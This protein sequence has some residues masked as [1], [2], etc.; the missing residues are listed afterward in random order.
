MK[1][2]SSR[3]NRSDLNKNNIIKPTFD[4]LTEEDRK[5]L[6]AYRANLEELF[7][8]CYEMTRQGLVLKDIMSI[9]IHKAEVTPEVRP[10]PSLSFDDI[11]SMINS[12]LERQAKSS[13]ELMCLLIEERDGKDLMI[14][15][16][17]LLLLTLLILLKP[18]HKQVARRRATL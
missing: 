16:S 14:L 8:S 7:Y 17:I 2:G 6:E 13:D 11:Q 9:I 18:I 12:V 4:T 1:K 15:M 10:N 5:A 3:V